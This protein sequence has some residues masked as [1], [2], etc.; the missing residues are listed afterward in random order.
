MWTNPYRSELL[1]P[2]L[3]CVVGAVFWVA[4]IVAIGQRPEKQTIDI[5]FTDIQITYR[6]AL[7]WE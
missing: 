5:P 3:L 1:R 2:A 7:N 6:W 4:V